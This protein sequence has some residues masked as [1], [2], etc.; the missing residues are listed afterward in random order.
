MHKKGVHERPHPSQTDREHAGDNPHR[1]HYT[2]IAYEN[3][4]VWIGGRPAQLKCDPV[5]RIMRKAVDAVAPPAPPLR[6]N[7][8]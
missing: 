1:S 4:V 8:R 3:K 2:A 7:E 5:F 6:V